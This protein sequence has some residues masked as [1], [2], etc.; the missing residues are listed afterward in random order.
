MVILFEIEN[1]H[2]VE[3]DFEA[4]ERAQTNHAS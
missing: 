4:M 3:C 1:I 2:I